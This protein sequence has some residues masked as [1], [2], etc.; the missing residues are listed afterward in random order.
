G[1]L[2]RDRLA[3]QRA[4]AIHGIDRRHNAAQLEPPGKIWFDHQRLENG[5]RISQPAGLDNNAGKRGNH[6]SIAA[7]HHGCD[8]IGKIAAQTAAEAPIRKLDEAVRARLDQLMVKANLA[9]FVDDDGGAREFRLPE[10]VT[11]QRRLAAAEKAREDN[12]TDHEDSGGRGAM[13]TRLAA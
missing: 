12:D 2:D 7:V 6:T 10:Q 5:S 4:R 3:L 8:G 9:E 11:Q 13:R 1:L